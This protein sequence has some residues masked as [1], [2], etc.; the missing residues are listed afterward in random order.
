MY[1]LRIPNFEVRMALSD[2]F[3]AIYT[4]AANERSSLQDRLYEVLEKADLTG[5]V[6]TVKRHTIAHNS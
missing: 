4:D 5:L 2:Q 1:R 6:H 3:I